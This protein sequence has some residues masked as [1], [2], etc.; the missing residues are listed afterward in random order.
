MNIQPMFCG[1]WKWRAM[2]IRR[3]EIE[4]PFEFAFPV[5][6]DSRGFFTETFNLQR[7]QAEG[8]A[9]SNWVQD[10]QSLSSQIHT[11]RGLHFQLKPFAQAKIVRVLSGAIY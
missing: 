1:V 11:L 6:E 8:L 9:E 4:G 2:Q 7:L 3:F 10:N 5:H